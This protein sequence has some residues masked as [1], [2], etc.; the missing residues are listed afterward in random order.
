[1]AL[2]LTTLTQ[3]SQYF[4]WGSQ[5]EEAFQLLKNKLCNAPILA[6]PEG[7]ENFMVY[8]DASRQGLGCVLMQKGKIIA[9]AFRQLKIHEKKYTTHDLELGAVIIKC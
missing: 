9:Y 7:T 3:K 5:Q 8:C 1:M 6:L 4:I 2:P